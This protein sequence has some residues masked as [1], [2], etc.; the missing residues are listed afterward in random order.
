MAPMGRGCAPVGRGLRRCWMRRRSA[1]W[2]GA[3]LR[4]WRHWF[5]MR[6]CRR[7]AAARL[8]ICRWSICRRPRS[9]G[10]SACM[11]IE[12]I[13]PLSPLQEGLL[14]HA[15]F[16]AQGPDIYTMQIGFALDGPLDSEV[17][18]AA[19][20]ALVQ[21]H[22]SLRAAFRHDNLSR[23]VQII[24]PA[25]RV[26][27]RSIDLSLLEEA[28]RE[29]R[30]ELLLLEDR[31][32]RFDF[33]AAPLVRFTVVR[34]GA[35][36]HRLLFTN[37]HILMDG[38]SVPV[39]VQELLTLYARRGDGRALPRVTPYRDYLAWIAAQ[40]RTAAV[41][42]WSAALSGLEE[43]TLVAAQAP[44]RVPVVSEKINFT[45]SEPLTTVLSQQ[46]RARGLTLNTYIQAAWAM[47][48]GRLTGRDDVVFGITVA[49]RPPEIAGIESMVGLFINTLPLRV[50][51]PPSK[52]VADLLSEL[53]DSQSR[54]M[55]HQ[56][57]GLAEI[58]GLVGLGE[59]FDTLVVF[60]N[61]PV[62]HAALAKAS[63]GL[64]ATPIAGHDASHYPL[65]LAAVPG[66]RLRLRL[67]YRP[68]LF[69]R[70]SVEALRGLL[71]RLLEASVAQPDCAIGR[72]DILDAAERQTLL[73][74]WNDT[75][76]AIPVATLPELFAAQAARSPEAVAVVFG[77]Q[78]LSYAA[79]DAR[80]NQLAHHLRNLGVGPEVVVGL[81]VERSLEMLV[82]LI[83][84]LKAG[85]AYLPLDP[86]YPSA[87]LAFM[88]EDAGAPVLLTQA[89]LR[90]RI[91]EHRGTIVE[92]DADWPAI[93]RQPTTAPGNTLHPQNTAYVIYTSGST[94]TPKG[95]AMG[96]GALSNL[97]SWSTH[98]T[99]GGPGNTVA[100]FTAISF[101]VSAQEIFSAI[102]T[103]KTLFLPTEDVR[104]NPAQLV[105]WLTSHKINE[106]FAPNLIIEALCDAIIEEGNDPTTLTHLA[107][108]GEALT[109]SE[110]LRKF[111]SYRSNVQLHNHY[112][113]TETHVVSAYDFP[114]DT[115]K[116]PELAPIG[117]PITNT[118]VYVLDSGLEPV[119]IGVV[120]EL[121]V[122]RTGLGRGYVGRCGLTA[123]RFVAN[124]FGMAGSRLYRTGDLARWRRDG[125]LEFLGRA[126]HQVK[127]RGFRIEPG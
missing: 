62:D 53:Q 41:A 38:W 49:G 68:D 52:P 66:E 3:G 99:Q 5:A 105:H 73:C 94:G 7:L 114:Q 18:R 22:A 63:N 124:P 85:G 121:Y 87:R 110:N 20:E 89:A 56:H 120:G 123:E 8:P 77:E 1:N 54:L 36:R 37:H 112:G 109:L 10:W 74:D 31:A 92:L 28:A 19:A 88:L 35:E 27:W 21:R 14:F 55:A 16:D 30:W 103:G 125:V 78:R 96:Y 100:Q 32:E 80:A 40:D 119:P 51:L 60:E 9:S 48:L 24:V 43:P 2:R 13:L 25:V 122:A 81:C 93:A 86:S 127:L 59:L 126:D 118:Q 116:W 117:R 11:R 115:L 67:E 58:Q 29:Q 50:K 98:Q 91:P 75:A 44:R 107:Q 6:R 34:L 106:F 70:V 72:L 33:A 65:S 95:V 39:V 82:G 26:P 15:L 17:L 83:G 79:L 113:P 90:Q 101:D 57:L 64:H 42:A 76:R 97:I 47:L 104:R 4:P 45:L 61:Y 71:I 102:T 108:A 84:I 69:D 23:P 12:D 46:A 111:F